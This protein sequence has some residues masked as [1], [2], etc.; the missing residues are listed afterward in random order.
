MEI[1]EKWDGELPPKMPEQHINY[2]LKEIGEKAEIIDQVTITRTSGG[3]KEVIEHNKYQLITNHTGRRS[4]CTNAYLSGMPA[5]DIM[6][7]SGHTS[8]RVFY[9]YIKVNDLQRAIKISEN[10]F[11]S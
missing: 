1:I 9:N 2:A 3:I 4:F 5:I 6:A 11:F 10:K 7:I 8:E